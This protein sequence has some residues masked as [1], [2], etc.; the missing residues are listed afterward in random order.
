M[1]N[2]ILW[3]LTSKNA[4]ISIAIVYFDIKFL[5]LFSETF[6]LQ[7]KEESLKSTFK[8]G[9]KERICLAVRNMY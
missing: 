4:F 6:L 7:S 8:E 5:V 9:R 2:P 3:K 1:L